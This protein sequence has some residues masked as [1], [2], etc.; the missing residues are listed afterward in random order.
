MIDVSE[1][2]KEGQIEIIFLQFFQDMTATEMKKSGKIILQSYLW[3][4]MMRID[5]GTLLQFDVTT[6]KLYVHVCRLTSFNLKSTF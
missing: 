4:C 1:L 2:S 6:A 5:V 3:I